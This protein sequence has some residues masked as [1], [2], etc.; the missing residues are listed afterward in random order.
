VFLA[1]LWIISSSNLFALDGSR[2]G[3][4]AGVGLGR[5]DL[6]Y[7]LTQYNFSI[8]GT[9]ISIERAN[10]N[11]NNLA[12]KFIFGYALNN[13]LI[14]NLSSKLSWFH[15]DKPFTVFEANK[16]IESTFYLNGLTGIGVSYYFKEKSPSLFF[17]TVL[18]VSH[19]AALKGGENRSGFG[20]S[21]GVGYEF[22]KHLSGNIDFCWGF[23]GQD[24]SDELSFSNIF[25][26]M[27]TLNILGY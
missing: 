23:P 16:D 11:L 9:L 24:D 10:N 22:V 25:T 17:S 13:Q 1:A 19:I 20:L 26:V 14:I 5:S 7:N 6:T 12:S 21:W 15:G 2:K 8:G 3:F 27:L 4:V 18:G